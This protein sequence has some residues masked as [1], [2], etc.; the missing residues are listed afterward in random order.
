MKFMFLSVVAILLFSSASPAQPPAPMLS[1]DA[2]QFLVGKWVGEGTTGNVGQG[3]GYFTF[4]ESLNGRVLVRKNRANYP[5]AKDRPA[6]SHEDL[7]IVFVDPATKQTRA[8]YTDSEGNV[9]QYTASF[10]KDG[11]ILT[12][13]SDVI[14]TTPRFRLTYVRTKPDQ[15]ALT[16][17][18]APPGKP[19][20]FR[21]FIVA[22]VRKTGDKN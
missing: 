8:F 6:V 10:S 5:A 15:M 16:F 1:W 4:E 19:D 21:K 3:T 13:L 18:I 2:W 7:M 11:N 14:P 20:E 22:T 12:F 17:E 9:I